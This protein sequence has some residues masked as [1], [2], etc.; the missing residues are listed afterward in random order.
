[1]P[2]GIQIRRDKDC[3]SGSDPLRRYE[4]ADEEVQIAKEATGVL[5]GFVIIVAVLAI[6]AFVAKVCFARL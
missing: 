6:T 5:I 2:K 3:H 1:M 4:S